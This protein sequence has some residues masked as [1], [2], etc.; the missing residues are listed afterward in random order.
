MSEQG[1]SILADTLKTYRKVLDDYEVTDIYAAATAAIRQA[2]NNQVIL[3]RMK[4]ETGITINLLSEE[5]EAYFGFLAVAH[6]MDTPS[7]VTIDI[8][9]GSTEITLFVNK[10]LQK[11]VS[12]PFGTVSLKQKFVSGDIINDEEK[13]LL[14]QYIKKQFEKLSW[15]QNVKLPVIAIGGSARN[16]AQVHQH[17]IDYP[18]SGIHQYEMDLEHL[19]ALN[20]FLGKMPYDQLKQ[21]DGL[22]A[23]R[24]DIIEIALEVFKTLMDV[25]GAK[26]FQISKKGLREGL[27]IH[28][29]LQ[30]EPKS[31]DKFNVFEENAR[32]IMYQYGRFEEEYQMLTMT[33]EQLYRECCRLN[34]FTFNEKHLSLL[35][36][37]A[38]VFSIGEYIENDSSNQHTFYLLA[39]QSIAGMSHVERV[40]LA[41]LASY[42]NK[43]YFRRFS[44]P[45]LN[46]IHRD[47]LKILREFG[48]LLKFVYSLNVSKRNVVKS[49]RLEIINNTVVINI[50]ASKHPMAEI[51]QSE[52]QK[53]HIE[54]VFKK[55]V[56][57]QFLK[58]GEMG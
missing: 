32:R 29:V 18:I 21:L 14:R 27:I 48:A 37:A 57:I 33:T 16:I 44:A 12:F 15:I 47:E 31:F 9:G 19:A 26:K 38:Q 58:E 5:Q 35:K 13:K 28:R 20:T 39:N 40:K 1:I 45:F 17:T 24:A 30:N 46:W 22:S 6:S 7:A 52:R 43:D 42:K 54:R 36:K 3:N 50:V 11:S 55:P 8:G 41:L 4:K 23:D 34:F 53:K 25:V 51:Y 2:T 49:I 10:T 56:K